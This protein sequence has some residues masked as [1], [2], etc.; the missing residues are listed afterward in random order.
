MGNIQDDTQAFVG[1]FCI[2]RACSFA[3]FNP[4]DFA[5]SAAIGTFML[6][7]ILENAF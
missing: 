5:L 6:E 3:F 4:A 7:T 1:V 2:H